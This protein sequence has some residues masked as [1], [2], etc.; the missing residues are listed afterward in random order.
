MNVIKKLLLAILIGLFIT[1]LSAFKVN[2]LRF[3]SCAAVEGTLCVAD[4]NTR[5]FRGI[6]GYLSRERDPSNDPNSMVD[7]DYELEIDTY[8]RGV[9]LWTVVVAAVLGLRELGLHRKAK[10][11]A[12]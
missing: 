12:K 3:A 10:K 5:E 6:P 4:K 2:Y 9:L 7:P 1:N 8:L 11:P